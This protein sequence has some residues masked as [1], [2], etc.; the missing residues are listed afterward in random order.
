MAICYLDFDM[1][2]K[3]ENDF[4]AG[5]QKQANLPRLKEIALTN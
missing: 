5:G 4:S 1:K 3:I 2:S